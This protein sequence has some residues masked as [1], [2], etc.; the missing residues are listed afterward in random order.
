MESP[1]Y[2]VWSSEPPN[3][4]SRMLTRWR[5]SRLVPAVA[6]RLA[7][8]YHLH[9]RDREELNGR[10]NR[11]QHHA[12]L[13]PIKADERG[14]LVQDLDHLPRLYVHLGAPLQ[15]ADVPRDVAADAQRRAMIQR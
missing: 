6:S 7:H 10:P 4:M 2:V 15:A 3:A 1:P 9:R 13:D 5:L 14:I 12:R 8:G 11:L